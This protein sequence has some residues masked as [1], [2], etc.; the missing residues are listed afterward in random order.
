M[1]KV[2]LYSVNRCAFTDFAT[3]S[4][5]CQTLTS[6]IDGF[7]PLMAVFFGNNI[8]EIAQPFFA[9]SI[10]GKARQKTQSIERFR[11]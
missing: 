10:C 4:P 1:T 6:K 2:H 11:F 3:R 5:N 8:F 7:Q 9:A